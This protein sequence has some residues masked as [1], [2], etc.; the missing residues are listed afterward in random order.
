MTDD[1]KAL[2]AF[3]TWWPWP[4]CSPLMHKEAG[5]IAFLCGAAWSRAASPDPAIVRALVAACEQALDCIR[6]ETP[7]DCT[8]EEARDHT[9]EKLRAAIALAEKLRAAIALAK[10]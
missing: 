7:E 4:R 1:P 5:R 8:H 2:A 3:E 6:G 10:D 9:I